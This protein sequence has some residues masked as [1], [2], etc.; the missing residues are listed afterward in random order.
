MIR[1]L[2]SKSSNNYPWALFAGIFL[3]VMM[4][5][6]VVNATSA[7]WDVTKD[8]KNKD[9][10]I[11]W[12]EL[13]D[14]QVRKFKANDIKHWYPLALGSIGALIGVLMVASPYL[15]KKYPPKLH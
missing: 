9:G 11:S 15:S 8:D 10:R 5:M 2:I 13:H 6:L 7:A 12:N 1:T 14:F 4:V 3:I